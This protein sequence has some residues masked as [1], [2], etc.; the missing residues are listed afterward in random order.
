M[1][2]ARWDGSEWTRHK[3]SRANASSRAKRGS[4]ALQP[5]LAELCLCK[6]STAA[7]RDIN[8]AA[9]PLPIALEPC[10]SH[11]ELRPKE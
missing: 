7:E 5:L 8:R 1:M 3:G 4:S 10:F 9:Q 6:I 11:P 2:A